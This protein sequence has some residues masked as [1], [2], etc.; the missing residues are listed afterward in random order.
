MPAKDQQ[1]NEESY[2]RKAAEQ[3]S[4]KGAY[5]QVDMRVPCPITLER[6]PSPLLLLQKWLSRN[7]DS[8]PPPLPQSNDNILC[9]AK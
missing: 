6:G 9:A 2:G 3:L 1:K 7:Y 8:T 5:Q 4:R